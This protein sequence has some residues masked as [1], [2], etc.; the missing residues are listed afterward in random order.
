MEG[1][2][3]ST[4]PSPVTRWRKSRQRQGLV[5]GE[6]QVRKTDAALAERERERER[7]TRAILRERIAKPREGG[8]KAL[9]APPPLDGIDRDRP[10]GFDR[11]VF[12]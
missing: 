12:L 7:E 6:V 4:D 9:V 5:R 3:A 11:D 1:S 8:L 2:V 10:C